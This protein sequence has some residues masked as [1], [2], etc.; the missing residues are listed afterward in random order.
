MA[1]NRRRLNNDGDDAEYRV[2]GLVDNLAQFLATLAECHQT[3]A[4][5]Y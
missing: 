2:G 4:E 1:P 3:E 5:Q